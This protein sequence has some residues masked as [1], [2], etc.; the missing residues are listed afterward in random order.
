MHL[1]ACSL[2]PNQYVFLISMRTM[3]LIFKFN[4]NI[5]DTVQSLAIRIES[6]VVL[7]FAC[8]YISFQSPL[9][10]SSTHP[11]IPPS[12]AILPSIL[13]QTRR[14]PDFPTNHSKTP[15]TRLL[16]QSSPKSP[17]LDPVNYSMGSEFHQAFAFPSPS[18]VQGFQNVGL[19]QDLLMATDKVTDAVSSLV[20][21][22]NTG[23]FVS[24]S[25]FCV[26]IFVSRLWIIF[27]SSQ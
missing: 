20:L 1:W 6:T 5:S 18:N 14:L 7:R 24:A 22:L 8:V 15:K 16:P 25:A 21:E 17:G 26:R 13:V 27:A 10:S 2:H 23:S 3:W 19:R 11:S 4:P 12:T 9:S